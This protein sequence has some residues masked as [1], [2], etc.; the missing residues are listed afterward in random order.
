[1]GTVDLNQFKAGLLCA[2]GGPSEFLND[3]VDAFGCQGLDL[4]PDRRA[5]NRRRRQ[6]F[7][8]DDP[9]RCLSSTMMNLNGRH[10]SLRFH[11]CGNFVQAF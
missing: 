11:Y 10:R 6:R 9:D 5:W 8:F 4:P 7:A 2:L 1:M 3:F